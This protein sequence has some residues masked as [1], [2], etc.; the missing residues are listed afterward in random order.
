MTRGGLVRGLLGLWTL[1]PVGALVH[2]Q[3]VAPVAQMPPGGINRLLILAGW[4]V[5]ALAVA[6]VLAAA[7]R[8][9]PHGRALRGLSILPLVVTAMAGG[10]LIL[11]IP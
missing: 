10:I 1:M 7:G 11:S 5:A 8:G 2:H 9:L 3:S 4:Y 6:A